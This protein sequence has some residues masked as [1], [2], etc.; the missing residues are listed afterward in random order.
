MQ[1]L[2]SSF[3]VYAA[4]PLHAL[5]DWSNLLYERALIRPLYRQKLGMPLIS[6]RC[7][8][9]F[10]KCRGTAAG[11]QNSTLCCLAVLFFW[12]RSGLYFT[13]CPACVWCSGAW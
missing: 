10:K 2:M 12:M 1:S 11:S 8:A 7:N 6:F 13:R 9:S 3:S 5:K 4:M